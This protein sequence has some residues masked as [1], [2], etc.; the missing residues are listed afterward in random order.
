[1]NGEPS[2]IT[3]EFR[4]TDPVWICA[5]IYAPQDE[6]TTLKWYDSEGEVTYEQSIPVSMYPAYRIWRRASNVQ[7]GKNEVRLYNAQGDLIG[8]RVFTVRSD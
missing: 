8:R 7:V 1:M 5:I 6:V 2:D 4:V 3:D